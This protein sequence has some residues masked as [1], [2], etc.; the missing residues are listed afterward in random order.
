MQVLWLLPANGFCAVAVKY[1]R[2]GTSHGQRLSC[3]ASRQD[4]VGTIQRLNYSLGE[5]SLS[6]YIQPILLG[7]DLQMLP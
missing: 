5:R 2:D 7:G 1:S 4:G 3:D 6:I